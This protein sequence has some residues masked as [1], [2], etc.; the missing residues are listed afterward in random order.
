[1]ISASTPPPDP[2]AHLGERLIAPTISVV[3]ERVRVE[4]VATRLGVYAP[5]CTM[6]PTGWI[7]SR[8]P[9]TAAHRC[10]HSSPH[11]TSRPRSPPS[12]AR[13]RP[14]PRLRGP[15]RS[16]PL[17]VSPLG[18]GR[19]PMARNP[20]AAY[21][22][23]SRERVPYLVRTQGCQGARRPVVVSGGRACRRLHAAKA[24]ANIAADCETPTA[25]LSIA[26]T[27]LSP[28]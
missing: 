22:T 6:S 3:D 16:L 21:R 24:K 9:G 10:T 15:C 26:P 20:V 12:Q 19:T 25:I 17:V 18:T 11:H 5:Q 1:M 7:S 23:A 28:M 2:T 14:S 8:S 4:G 27:L 13:L